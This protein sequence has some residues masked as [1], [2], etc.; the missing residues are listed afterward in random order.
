MGF[1]AKYGLILEGR[2][3]TDIA[4]LMTLKLFMFV[5]LYFINV[6]LDLSYH[7]T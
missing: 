4:T 7:H 6:D 5:V 1:R 2:L 3:D